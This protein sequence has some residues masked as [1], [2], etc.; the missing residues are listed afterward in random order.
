MQER[1][2]EFATGDKR[3]GLGLWGT[4]VP[5][6]VQGQSR[7]GGLGTKPPQAEDKC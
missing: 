3:M 4:E 7:G 1:S 5:I 6:G 2:Q